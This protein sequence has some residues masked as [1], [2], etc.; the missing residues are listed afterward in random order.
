MLIYNK[1]QLI[2]CYVG[3]DSRIDIIKEIPKLVRAKMEE[4]EL[5]R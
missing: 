1:G 2:Y 4:N 3:P 5:I